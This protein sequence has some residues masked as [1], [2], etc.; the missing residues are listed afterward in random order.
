[1]Y[2]RAKDFNLALEDVSIVSIKGI[3]EWI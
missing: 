3:I 1:L 2:K